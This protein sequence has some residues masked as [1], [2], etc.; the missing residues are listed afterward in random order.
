MF[1][2]VDF[3]VGLCTIDQELVMVRGSPCVHTPLTL[4]NIGFI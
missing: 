4:I 1:T 2:Y 3:S